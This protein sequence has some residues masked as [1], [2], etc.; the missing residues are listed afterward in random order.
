MF[1]NQ[2][3]AKCSYLRWILTIKSIVSLVDKIGWQWFIDTLV[4]EQIDRRMVILIM[5]LILSVVPIC[6]NYDA[7]YHHQH[8]QQPSLAS[9]FATHHAFTSII[10]SKQRVY[11][12]HIGMTSDISLTCNKVIL[13]TLCKFLLSKQKTYV[14]GGLVW[15]PYVLNFT[16]FK[17]YGPSKRVT[18]VWSR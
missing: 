17:I 18:T 8:H 7:D 12:L 2:V 3:V 1:N 16:P 15:H 6:P 13:K 9:S 4:D 11:I 5:N 14:W 10:P